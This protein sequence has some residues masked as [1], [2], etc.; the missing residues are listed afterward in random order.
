MDEIIRRKESAI[1]SFVNSELN[2]EYTE[3]EKRIADID[4]ALS[5]S[6]VQANSLQKQCETLSAKRDAKEKEFWSSG[7]ELGRNREAIKAEMKKNVGRC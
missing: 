5:D 3:V 6:V 4:A 1:H 2:Q 7:G